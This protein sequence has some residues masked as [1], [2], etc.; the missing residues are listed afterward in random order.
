MLGLGNIAIGRTCSA[1]YTEG[2][3]TRSYESVIESATRGWDAFMGEE[4]RILAEVEIRRKRAEKLG[5]SDL[6]TLFCDHL[7]YLKDGPNA[8]R[9][10]KS[11]SN[12]RVSEI[13]SGRD[14]V[15]MREIFFGEKPY[16]FVFKQHQCVDPSGE[17][18]TIGHLLLLKDGQTL[19]DLSVLGSVE[20][21]TGRV[22]TPSTVEA[23]I[24]GPWVEEIKRFA[25]EVFELSDQRQRQSQ[26]EG[27]KKELEDL[28][29]KFGIQ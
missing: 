9:L 25:Q 28:K 22:W 19:F 16:A 13:R 26:S 24:E 1:L 23:F 27:K 12:V 29:K 20:E 4:E 3:C 15:Q 2:D 7:E 14:L 17:L 18:D 6:L 8:E 10:P 11:V 5:L 21:W